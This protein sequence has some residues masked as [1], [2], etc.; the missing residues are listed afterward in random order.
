MRLHVFVRV[1]SCFF[2]IGNDL[3]SSPTEPSSHQA[4]D[5]DEPDY[6]E[7]ERTLVEETEDGDKRSFLDDREH[8]CLVLPSVGNS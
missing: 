6:V 1:A 3:S 8:K 5:H 7:D 2:Q 4:V